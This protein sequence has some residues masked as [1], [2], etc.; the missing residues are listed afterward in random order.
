MVSLAKY[1]KRK[2]FQTFK[3]NPHFYYYMFLLVVW[4]YTNIS[5]FFWHSYMMNP[6]KKIEKFFDK[7]VCKGEAYEELVLAS[8]MQGCKPYISNTYTKVFYALNTLYLFFAIL[9]IRAGKVFELSKRVDYGNPIYK[10]KY[11]IKKHAPLVRESTTVFEYCAIRTCLR[12]TDFLLLKDIK[13]NLNYAKIKQTQS[14]KN[15][16]GREIKRIS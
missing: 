2:P 4:V 12:F 9:E 1:S 10:L 16:V 6:H 7:F 8:D 13:M 15:P 14:T 5:V 11:Y 3:N